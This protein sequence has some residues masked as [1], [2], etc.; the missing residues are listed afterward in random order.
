MA[1]SP[2]QKALLILKQIA[3]SGQPVAVNRLAQ[4]LGLN[5]STVHR[6]LQVLVAEKMVSYCPETRLYGV[7]ADWV[8]LASTV[9]GRESPLSRMRPALRALA[10]RLQETCAYFAFEPHELTK[11]LVLLERGPQPLGY[12]F[13][14]GQRDGLN[15]G[16]SGKSILAFLPDGEIDRFFRTVE[17]SS[18]TD[19]TITDPDALRR[20][21]RQVRARGYATSL[22][23]RVPGA[24]FGTAAPVFDADGRVTGS[25]VLT[26]PLFRWR[27]E[28]LPVKAA[29]VVACGREMSALMG[30]E[31]SS[32][33]R[34]AA[35]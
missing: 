21:I 26:V 5:A 34:D 6:L 15:A 7:G 31:H 35:P 29:A 24:G 13:A 9:L 27:K 18:V 28:D 19:R 33:S 10:A 17:L 30:H 32:A 2:L 16:A 4:D 12:E 11:T 8:A 1:E 14:V 23:E 20:E 22:G 3:R 25:V